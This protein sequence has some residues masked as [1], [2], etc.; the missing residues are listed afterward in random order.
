MKYKYKPI[1]K[2]QKERFEDYWREKQAQ[3]EKYQS[4]FTEVDNNNEKGGENQMATFT[5]EEKDFLDDL[6]EEAEEEDNNEED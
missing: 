3:Q 2:E 4:W 1:T 6:M 5:Q